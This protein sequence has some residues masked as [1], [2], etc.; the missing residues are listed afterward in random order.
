MASPPLKLQYR[1]LLTP[2]FLLQEGIK[3]WSKSLKSG[4]RRRWNN[5]VEIDVCKLCATCTIYIAFALI[6]TSCMETGTKG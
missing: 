2:M 3:A 4:K 6:Q 1:I 5:L